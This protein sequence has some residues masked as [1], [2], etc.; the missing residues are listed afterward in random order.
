MFLSLVWCT[1]SGLLNSWWMNIHDWQ[2]RKREPFPP[3]ALFLINKRNYHCTHVCQQNHI[4]PSQTGW[5]VPWVVLC[6]INAMLHWILAGWK[7]C[8]R[9]V[10]NSFVEL[11]RLELTD[12][13]FK[14]H[15]SPLVQEPL[16]TSLKKLLW[17]TI[18][19]SHI[20]ASVWVLCP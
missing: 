3:G 8:P 4:F 20:S 10:S 1:Y 6:I 9:L 16:F 18:A 5:M 14:K 19:Y 11:N 13:S 15:W 17:K 12:H 2:T 7:N